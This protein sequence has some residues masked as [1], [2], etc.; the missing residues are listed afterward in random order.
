MSPP[1]IGAVLENASLFLVYNHVQIMVREY[2]TPNYNN[3]SQHQAPL[4]ISIVCFAG[5]LSGASAS[6]FLTPI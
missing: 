4:P 5:A 1:M 2:T 3:K 6:F